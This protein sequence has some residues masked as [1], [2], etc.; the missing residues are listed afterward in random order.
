MMMFHRIR[1]MIKKIK[2]LPK[3]QEYVLLLT[4]MPNIPQFIQIKLMKAS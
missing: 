2:K 1:Q 4:V 3:I